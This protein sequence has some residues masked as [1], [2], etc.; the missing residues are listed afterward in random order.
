M[1]KNCVFSEALMPAALLIMGMV[2]SCGHPDEFPESDTRY[3][4]K[5]LNWPD[6]NFAGISL[7]A[8]IVRGSRTNLD[9]CNEN[10]E[11]PR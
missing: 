10:R 2:F 8:C 7:T 9:P 6:H 1:E 5:A 4:E 3:A 11:K